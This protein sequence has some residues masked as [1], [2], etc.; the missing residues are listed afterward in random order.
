MLSGT[1]GGP[2]KEK[3]LSSRLVR[4]GDNIM[5]IRLVGRI[6]PMREKHTFN[7]RR[8]GE[9]DISTRV[10]HIDAVEAV[11]SGEPMA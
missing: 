1:C 7:G 8:T 2:C 11:G 10:V 6:Q 4:H 9:L 3:E 5:T